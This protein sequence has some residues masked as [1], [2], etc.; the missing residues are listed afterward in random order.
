MLCV[1]TLLGWKGPAF[2]VQHL[3][4]P[5]YAKFFG[6][7]VGWTTTATWWFVAIANDLYLAQFTLGLAEALNPHYVPTEWH[8]YL[9]YCA[10]ALATFLINLPYIF[11]ILGPVLIGAFALINVTAVFILVSLL[12]RATPKPSA[13]Q[14]FVD[15]V[16]ESGWSSTGVVFFLALLPAVLCVSGFDAMTHIT[17]ELDVPTKQVPQVIIGSSVISAIT[18]FCMTIVYSFCIVEP[19]N[20]LAPYGNQPIIQLLFDSCRSKALAT[21]G[22][23]GVILSFY[24]ASVSTFTSW[25]RL[26]WSLSRENL[27]PFSKLTAKLSVI[28][29]LPV[30]AMIINLLLVVA[31]GAIQIGSLTALNAILGGAVVCA[32]VSYCLTFGCALWRGRNYFSRTR[33]LNLHRYGTPI[34]YIAFIWCVFI[35]VWLCF[36]LYLPVT[37]VY[38]NWASVVVVGVIAGAIIYWFVRPLAHNILEIS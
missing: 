21:I 22:S 31:L 10:W 33:W 4:P 11:R 27:F 5:K 3:A 30:N 20:L 2:W 34:F 8:Y 25:S 32:T 17:D 38:M 29:S 1:L 35:S 15:V 26:Y 9:V 19:Q 7:L 37:T 16:N 24:I 14:V 23:I 36:P 28:D 13:Q 12:V 6:F 18:G